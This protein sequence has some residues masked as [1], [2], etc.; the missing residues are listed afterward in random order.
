MSGFLQPTWFLFPVPGQNPERGR[1]VRYPQPRGCLA[2][3]WTGRIV[4]CLVLCPQ[5]MPGL[6]GLD[7]C[8]LDV[9]YTCNTACGYDWGRVISIPPLLSDPLPSPPSATPFVC[10]RG[11]GV[12]VRRAQ[13]V[14]YTFG[15]DTRQLWLAVS[16]SAACGTWVPGM[17]TA[18]YLCPIWLLV[19]WLALS[20]LRRCSKSLLS[21][22]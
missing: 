3:N 14:N 4:D 18:A 15:E 21:S 9:L 12:I 6:G 13:I 16:W 1:Q 20:D 19:L 10:E 7:V 17:A 2:Y 8:T 5:Q 22:G 11:R